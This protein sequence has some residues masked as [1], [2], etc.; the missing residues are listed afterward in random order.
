EGL[1]PQIFVNTPMPLVGAGFGD[2]VNHGAGVAPVLRVEGIRENA[3]FRN[4][5]GRRLNRRR[6]YEKIVAIPS[7]HVEVVGAPATSIDRHRSRLVAAVKEIGSAN[8][9][10]ARL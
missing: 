3:E 5:V 8:P 1:I 6:I 10:H 9:L 2:N 4:A 7:I